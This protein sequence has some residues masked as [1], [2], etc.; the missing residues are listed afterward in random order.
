MTF[1]D[2]HRVL[3]DDDIRIHTVSLD[4]PTTVFICNAEL[5]HKYG[6]TVEQRPMASTA[7]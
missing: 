3:F 6:A 2:F 5:W 1:Q 4:D 7:G